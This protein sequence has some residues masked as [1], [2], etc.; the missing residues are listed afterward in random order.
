MGKRLSELISVPLLDHTALL[1]QPGKMEEVVSL[2]TTEFGWGEDIMRRTKGDWGK[3]QFVV[4]PYGATIQLTELADFPKQEE[5]LPAV[6][7]GLRFLDT[8]LAVQAITAWAEGKTKI[9]VEDLDNGKK[10]IW[11]SDL[12]AQKIELI[13]AYGSSWL[14]VEIQHDVIG[15]GIKTGS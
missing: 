4:G 9:E 15:I 2:F 12:L 3:A 14:T 8:A 13:P 10:F 11:L 1:V 7:L 6:H 5:P